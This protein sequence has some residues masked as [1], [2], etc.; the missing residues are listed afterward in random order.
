MTTAADAQSSPA[1]ESNQK[2][3]WWRSL[4]PGIITASVVIG[5]GSIVVSSSV[6]A[7]FGY[8]ML[9]ALLITGSFMLLFT[10]MATRIG[11][12]KQESA[13]TQTARIY[14]R[15][16][17]VIVGILAFT[18][19]ASFQMGNYLACSTALETLTGVDGTLWIG[20]VGVVAFVFVFAARQLYRWI[21]RVMMALVLVMLASFVVNLLIARPDLLGILSGLVPRGWG[22]EATG[23]MAALVATTFSVIAA[24]YQSTLAQQK[25]WRADDLSR[26]VRGSLRGVSVLIV[27]TFMIMITSATVL[28]GEQIRD[29][30]HLAA[31]LEPLLG[32]TA[33]VLFSL[34]FLAAAFSSTIVNAMVGGGLLADGL[35]LTA[36]V[37][38][39][40]TRVFTGIAMVVGLI[41]GVYLMKAGTPIDGIVLAQKSTILAVP[42]CAL[43]IILLA[44]HP[45]VVGDHRMPW[46]ANTWAG[47][48]FLVLCGM[49]VF[50][51]WEMASG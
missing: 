40:S 15:W 25:G 6:G 34:G 35:G 1:G 30:A 23:L 49:S 16:L 24:L 10:A 42:L 22:L 38:A 37:N 9:W 7:T 50:R 29:A 17:A 8:G 12:L 28:Q 44:N 36:N 11:V 5:P 41:A 48:A 18:V 31:Q 51:I 3:N 32:S 45:R 13:L 14:G 46:W 20:V 2:Q 27:V 43:V 47:F 33:V 26:A 4:G 39:W 19:C 21:E